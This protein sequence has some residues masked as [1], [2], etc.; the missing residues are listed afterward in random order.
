MSFK[1]TFAP[2]AVPTV[3]RTLFP[4]RTTV[5]LQLRTVPPYIVGAFFTL[6]VS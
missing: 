4:G 1:L 5:Q 6:A 3:I 2:F